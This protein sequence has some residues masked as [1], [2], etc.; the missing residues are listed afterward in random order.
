MTETIGPDQIGQ[1]LLDPGLPDNSCKRHSRK[2]NH[3]ITK[4]ALP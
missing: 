1:V 2:Y 3:I 4:A